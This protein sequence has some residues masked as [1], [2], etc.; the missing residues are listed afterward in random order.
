MS[1][2][3]NVPYKASN[4]KA[5]EAALRNRKLADDL[6]K[7]IY[8]L[9][10]YGDGNG[11]TITKWIMDANITP[12]TKSA[13]KI[14]SAKI[15]KQMAKAL[16]NRKTA[17]MMLNAIRELQLLASIA[18][19]MGVY[20]GVGSAP[21]KA[22]ILRSMISSLAN[23][24]L[25]KLIQEAIYELQVEFGANK[26]V[27][28]TAQANANGIAGNLTF[29]GDGLSAF[30]ALIGGAYTASAGGDRIPSLG[31]IM[32][33][34]GGINDTP[35]VAAS[36]NGSINVE[37]GGTATLTV[38]CDTAGIAG[39]TSITG[40][41]LTDCATLIGAGYT[42]SAGGAVILKNGDVVNI[43]GGADFIAGAKASFTGNRSAVLTQALFV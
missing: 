10:V 43:A 13:Y 15:A 38:V 23:K 4:Q 6:I 30:S 20:V 16:S 21:F 1:E 41:G 3:F 33:F 11:M 31:Q 28:F 27:T 9:Q 24:K 22:S 18:P 25:G 40:D 14:D 17:S 32:I 12:S 36:Y 42:I 29:T 2:L 26:L 39:N 8:E 34:A 19:I 37:G 5:L 35:A 7:A